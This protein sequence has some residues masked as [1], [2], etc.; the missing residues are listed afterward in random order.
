MKRLEITV[1]KN[2]KEIFQKR[3]GEGREFPAIPLP[4]HNRHTYMKFICYYKLWHLTKNYII[5]PFIFDFSN[6]LPAF[7]P[8]VLSAPCPPPLIVP[9]SPKPPS[10]PFLSH[11]TSLQVQLTPS[12]QPLV[13][14]D[15]A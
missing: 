15:F 11:S 12:F 2:C 13:P 3:T 1:M 9:A 8:K 7:S 5:V 10:L 6:P 4:Y 14:F